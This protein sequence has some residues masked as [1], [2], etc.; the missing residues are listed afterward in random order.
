MSV[1][2]LHCVNYCLRNWN[3]SR[4]THM[5]FCTHLE[6]ELDEK[7]FVSS[8]QTSNEIFHILFQYYLVSLLLPLLGYSVAGL[9][10]YAFGFR[11][12]DRIAIAV[13]T[14][15]FNTL[16]A[17]A[18]ITPVLKGYSAKE[19][20]IFLSNLMFIMTPIPLLIHFAWN[21]IRFDYIH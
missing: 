13:E 12:K 5:F 19:L 3:D 2:N 14:I 4:F 21:K 9:I 15:N 7:G 8:K 17:L 16:I 6:G 10:A 20:A 11:Y 18:T 1:D